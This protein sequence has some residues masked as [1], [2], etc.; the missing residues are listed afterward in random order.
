MSSD[1][2]S[3]SSCLSKLR[4]IPVNSPSPEAPG[5]SWN[6]IA[7][8]RFAVL[9]LGWMALLIPT[10][11]RFMGTVWESAAQ[12]HGPIVLAAAMY[13]LW[14]RRSAIEASQAPK[15]PA[16]GA[17]MLL[18]GLFVYA[19]G[20]LTKLAVLEGFGFIPVVAG[21]LWMVGGAPLIKRLWFPMLYLFLTVPIPELV[22]GAAT[23]S[24]KQFV[25]AT[26]EW[27]LYSAGYPIARDGV[28]LTIGSYQLLVAD[29][30][31]G[32]NSIISLTAVGLLYIEISRPAKRWQAIAIA[33]AIFPIAIL[34]NLARVAALVL[35]TYYLGDEAGQGFLHEAAGLFMFVIAVL[36]LFGIDGLMRRLDR[37]RAP[38]VGDSHG[39]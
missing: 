3:M 37:S 30:C 13:L 12:S 18:T 2:R 17:L 10:A 36:A 35:I 38:A 7:S 19:F 24:L 5:L 11:Y 9:G 29:A 23:S 4:P 25:S 14:S 34:A 27:I 33:L 6:R 20:V 31:S 21:S 39:S 32:M 8:S 16:L 22:L 26:D 15:N 1:A 28:T